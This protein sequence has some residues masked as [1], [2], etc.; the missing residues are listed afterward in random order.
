M[1]LIESLLFDGQLC[2][3][4]ATHRLS[5]SSETLR[6]RS[7]QSQQPI[8]SLR[9]PEFCEPELCELLGYE[10]TFF[11]S[12][13]FGSQKFGSQKLGSQKFG[14]QK[15]WNFFMVHIFPKFTNFR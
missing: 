12:Q 3:L 15:I 6:S 1:K 9:E 13:D 4:T 11:G 8:S 10:T 5:S 7:S 2:P 14:S